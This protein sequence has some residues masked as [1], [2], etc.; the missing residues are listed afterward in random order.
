ME[1]S[2]SASTPIWSSSCGFVPTDIRESGAISSA[3]FL[4]SPGYACS[5]SAPIVSSTGFVDAIVA[6]GFRCPTST[7]RRVTPIADATSADPLS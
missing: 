6:P 4:F 2:S 7:E 1:K 3:W 5:S